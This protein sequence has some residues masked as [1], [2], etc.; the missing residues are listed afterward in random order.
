MSAVTIRQMAERVEGLMTERLGARGSSFE[1]RLR[2]CGRRL[3][4]RVRRAARALG[5]AAEMTQNPKLHA[6]LD[7]GAIARDYDIC[8]RY[9]GPRAGAGRDAFPRL[10]SIAFALLVTGGGFLAFL[11]WRGRL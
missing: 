8:L 7:E 3:P 5:Q 4:R 10:A 1:A 11:Y 9:L 2:S 6:R